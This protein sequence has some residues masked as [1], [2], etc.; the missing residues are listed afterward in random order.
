MKCVNYTIHNVHDMP[1]YVTYK[2]VDN[3][4][5]LFDSESYK[6]IIRNRN[7]YS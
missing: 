2:V 7:L 5:S 3:L 1:S 4:E 6:K